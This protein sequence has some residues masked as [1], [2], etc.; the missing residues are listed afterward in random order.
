MI[1]EVGS[2]HG[3]VVINGGAWSGQGPSPLPGEGLGRSDGFAGGLAEVG[4]VQV[5]VDRGR[6]ER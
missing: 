6:G 3:G 2:A 1:R 5:P 4:V